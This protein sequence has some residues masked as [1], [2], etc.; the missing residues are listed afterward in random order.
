MDIVTAGLFPRA[1]GPIVGSG[2]TREKGLSYHHGG[3][4]PVAFGRIGLA[5]TFLLLAKGTDRT[6]TGTKGFVS[7]Q[8]DLSSS[9]DYR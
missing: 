8:P 7:W 1:L 4:C 3:P 5:L 9:L 6:Q 2:D